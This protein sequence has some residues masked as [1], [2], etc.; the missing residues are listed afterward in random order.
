MVALPDRPLRDYSR[1]IDMSDK[2][3]VFREHPPG[4][5]I[6]EGRMIDFYDHRAKRYVSGHGNSSLWEE[7]AFGSPRKCILPQWYVDPSELQN[8]D[9][10]TRISDY[11]IG[12]MDVADP[13]RQRSFVSAVIPPMNVCGHKV[14]TLLF[15]GAGWY[16]P[17]Y[18][19]IANSVVMDFLA[20]QRTLSKSMSF[21]IL[22]SLPIPRLDPMALS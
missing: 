6:Y 14:P 13:G 3:G 12:F 9:V 2:N 22:D 19:A 15:P 5:P 18:L 21:N 16:L 4:M 20:R 7:T 1:E 17:V 10:R 8:D 11:R